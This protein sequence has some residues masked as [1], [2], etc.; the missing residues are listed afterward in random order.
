MPVNEEM[1]SEP[2]TKPDECSMSFLDNIESFREV[3]KK[4]NDS[5]RQYKQDV[6]D[7]LWAYSE[8]EKRVLSMR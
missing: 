8:A 3:P 7:L 4:E 6:I 5:P 2:G 1:K